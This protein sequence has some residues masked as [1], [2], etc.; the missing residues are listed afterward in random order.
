MNCFQKYYRR[1]YNALN[2]LI[3]IY[4][5]GYNKNRTFQFQSSSKLDFMRNQRVMLEEQGNFVFTT[6]VA[7]LGLNKES[8]E[9]TG[10]FEEYAK[11]TFL[12]NLR[13]Q[14]LASPLMARINLFDNMRVRETDFDN[15]LSIQIDIPGDTKN[16]DHLKRVRNGLLHSN[17]YV[18]DEFPELNIAHIKTKSYYESE[19]LGPEFN[20]FVLEYFSNIKELGLTEKIYTYT[21]LSGDIKTREQ[22][23]L[24]LKELYINIFNYDKLKTM[25]NNTPELLMKECNNNGVVDF[26]AFIE[27]M[28]KAQNY[29]NFSIDSRQLSLMEMAHMFIY[30]E[31]N[32]GDEFFEMSYDKQHAII[33]SHLQYLLNPKREI[34]NWLVHFSYLYS[35]LY[36]GRFNP[37]FFEGD[38]FATESCYPALM[39]LKAYLIMYRMQQTDFAEIDYDNIYDIT[40]DSLVQLLSENLKDPNDITNYF[41]E[42]FDS[43][44]AK[45]VLT[46]DKEI[47]NKVICEVI[48]NSL[49][50]G[51]VIPSINIKT[52]EAEIELIDVDKKHDTA[53]KIKMPLKTFEKFLNSE[54]F[55]PRNCY[56]K[57]ETLTLN[58]KKSE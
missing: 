9:N 3:E 47:W 24:V 4:K 2:K 13:T 19:V 6:M 26:D 40:S 11:N 27:K 41:K 57:D 8:I 29:D 32:Y 17:F 14:G 5:N 30:I 28:K 23:F 55:Q 54:A 43:E 35:T 21:I 25:C 37:M 38:E 50:H 39:I 34:S 7:L 56:A 58:R 10:K 48:R 49:A 15:W 53:R 22:L 36:N 31:R 33:S 45:R 42:S 52:F 51:N 16:I 1:S 12:A 20:M 44:K 18:D 46:T